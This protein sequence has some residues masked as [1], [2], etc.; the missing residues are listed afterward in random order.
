[1]YQLIEMEVETR[2]GLEHIDILMLSK[3]LVFTWPSLNH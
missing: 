1:M 3:L 2:L